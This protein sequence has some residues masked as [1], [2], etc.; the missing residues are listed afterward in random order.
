MVKLIVIARCIPEDVYLRALEQTS[1]ILAGEK[2]F[3]LAIHEP[4][5]WA[6]GTLAVQITNKYQSIYKRYLHTESKS[7][8]SF[9]TCY[10]GPLDK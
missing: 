3:S 7:V 8:A 2:K 10:V 6:I 5:L 1:P 4:E 9:L